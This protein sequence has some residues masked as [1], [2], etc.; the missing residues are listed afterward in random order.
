MIWFALLQVLTLSVGS[1]TKGDMYKLHKCN[2]LLDEKEY[3]FAIELLI[4]G[5]L[6]TIL[7]LCCAALKSFK[8][9]LK[10]F[11]FLTVL[12]GVH[13]YIAFIFILACAAYTIFHIFA[14]KFQ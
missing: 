3:F 13:G 1:N 7:F 6:Y 2:F 5:I 4:Y 10:D 9:K 12:R 8:C 14:N 11:I